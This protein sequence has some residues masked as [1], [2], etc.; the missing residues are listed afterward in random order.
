MSKVKMQAASE[1]I[2]EKRYD[3]ARALLE[4]VDHPTAREWLHKLD[5]LSPSKRIRIQYILIGFGI[6]Y[7]VLITIVAA[8][9]GYRQIGMSQDLA[10]WSGVRTGIAGMF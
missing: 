9:L 10:T 4:Q 8:F 3:E 5:Q 1:L 2:K 6:G 7:A